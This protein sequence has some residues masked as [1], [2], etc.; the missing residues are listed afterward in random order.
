M[1]H[2]LEDKNPSIEELLEGVEPVGDRTPESAQ[3][4]MPAT[5]VGSPTGRRVPDARSPETPRAAAEPAQP[6]RNEPQPQEPNGHRDQA[7]GHR[8]PDAPL[9]YGGDHR[10]VRGVDD[11]FRSSTHDAQTA[12]LSGS[13]KH[14][15]RR[16]SHDEANDPRYDD[17]RE[18]QLEI[19]RLKPEH[20]ASE[21]RFREPNAQ[22][23]SGRTPNTPDGGHTPA[24]PGSPSH[25]PTPDASEMPVHGPSRGTEDAPGATR[26][27]ETSNALDAPDIPSQSMAAR[28]EGKEPTNSRSAWEGRSHSSRASRWGLGWRARSRRSRS[29]WTARCRLTRS[30]RQFADRNLHPCRISLAGRRTRVSAAP[31]GSVSRRL[32]PGT[33]VTPV[34]SI[35]R[36]SRSRSPMDRRSVRTVRS[37]G[38]IGGPARPSSG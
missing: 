32:R 18:L 31:N 26:T 16:P 15:P 20:A 22:D 13:P 33:R 34:R 37:V 21:G 17:P 3:R 1:A 6:H 5:R 30:G 29:A 14:Q 8:V 25:A 11:R 9:R 12:D 28:L 2:R 27:P 23:P 36:D 24:T 38:R 7:A 4:M 35:E 10:T 19:D